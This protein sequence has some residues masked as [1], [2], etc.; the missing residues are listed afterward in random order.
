[1]TS[2]LRSQ[3]AFSSG[4]PISHGSRPSGSGS[5]AGGTMRPRE[6]DQVRDGALAVVAHGDFV[7]IE[8]QAKRPQDLAILERLAALARGAGMAPSAGGA[9]AGGSA[10]AQAI[11]V[12]IERG[13]LRPS[14]LAG[15]LFGQPRGNLAGGSP[16]GVAPACQQL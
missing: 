12:G 11:E 4:S 5:V 14:A 1:M 6:G 16:A 9:W 10:V 3:S 13:M 8:L 15:F 7:V 2:T